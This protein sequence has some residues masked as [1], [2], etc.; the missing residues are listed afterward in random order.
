MSYDD[1][2]LKATTQEELISAVPE[3]LCGVLDTIGTIYHDE[4]TNP[5]AVPGFHANLR[6]KKGA[7]VPESLQPFLI[8]E[9]QIKKRVWL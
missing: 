7:A 5:V 9:P 8:P 4:D 3:D 6:M 2:Y 1:Y